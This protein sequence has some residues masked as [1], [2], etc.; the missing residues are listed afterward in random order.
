[1]AIGVTGLTVHT[2]TGGGTWKDYGSGGGSSANTDVFLSSTGSRARKIS[3]GQKGF[4]YEVNA[5]GTDLS[6]TVIAIRWATLA[7]VGAL[8]TL[9]LDG[10][11]F[12]IEDTS[13]NISYYTIAGNDTYSGG[14]EVSVIDTALTATANNG[15]AATMTAVQYVGI[16]WDETA[17]VG[18][19]DPN[20]YIDEIL[21]W[22]NTGL[23]ITGNSTALFAD[24]Q[25][26]DDTNDYGIFETRGGIV[27]SKAYL[28]LSPD[29]SDFASTDETVVFEDKFFED[30]TNISSAL[31]THGMESADADVIQ[32]NRFTCIADVNPDI[33]GTA[34]S[35]EINFSSATG[36]DCNVATFKAFKS[37]TANESIQLGATGNTYNDV[38]FIGNNSMTHTSGATLDGCTFINAD[39]ADG[40]AQIVT[41]NPGNFSNCDFTFSDGHAIEITATGTYT[42]DGNTF[43]NYGADATNDAAIYNSTTSGTVTLN[44]QNVAT[45]PTVRT[46]SGG[47]TVAEITVT[48]RVTVLDADDSTPIQGARVLLEADTGGDLTV[49]TDIL[50]NTTNASGVVED[51]AF[52]FTNPQPVTGR[53]RKGSTSTYYKTSN[54]TGTITS[55]GFDVNIFMVKDE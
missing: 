34:S 44:L 14:W 37:T 30:G 1:M 48:V 26:W 20:C 22:P 49:G 43:T 12:I 11:R 25:A 27:F 54:I 29:A 24:L 4:A 23:T 40:E 5:S 3:N 39:T 41:N 19:G 6:N 45:V 42:F 38:S 18:G 21:S 36:I 32:F 7:G 53:V 47:T 55:G 28:I 9:A 51:T 35:K 15:T 17:S 13:G 52:N 31:G 2:Q 33:N 16:E 50:L 10:V 46:A 8:N